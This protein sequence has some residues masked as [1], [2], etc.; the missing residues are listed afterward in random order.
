MGG[1]RFLERLFEADPTWAVTVFGDEPHP[2][3]DRVALSKVLA[4]SVGAETVVIRGHDWYDEKGIRLEAGCPIVAIN[5]EER[6]VEDAFGRQHEYDSLVLATGSLPFMPPIPGANLDGV[7][8]FRTLDEVDNMITRAEAG[9]KAVVIGGGLLGL[10]CAYGLTRRGMDVTVLHLTEH[11]MDRQLDLAAGTLLR[12]ELQRMGMRVMLPVSTK[13]FEGD[14]RVERVVLTDGE[15]IPADLVVICAGIRPNISLARDAGLS[16]AKGI[17]VDDCLHTSAPHV[18]ALGEC[19]EHKG[20]TFGLVEPVYDQAALLAKIIGHQELVAYE[21][22][23]SAT[24][25]KVA[26]LD[27]FAGGRS[28]PEIGDHEV[29]IRDDAGFIYKKLVLR[30][31]VVVGATLLGDVRSAPLVGAALS[32]G[33]IVKD[34]LRLLGIGIA[35]ESNPAAEL[36]DLAVVCGCNGVT[37]ATIMEAIQRPEEGCTSR[38]CVAKCTRASTSCGSCANIVDGLLAYAGQ[39][40]STASPAPVVCTCVPVAREELRWRI[41]GEDIRTVS[42]VLK[43]AGDGVGCHRCRPAINYYL[44]AWWC[45]DYQ[46]QPAS[47]HVNDRVHANVQKDGTFSVVPRMRGGITTPDDLRRIADVAD[48]Y[49]VGMVKLTGGQRIDLLGVKK[50]DLP[51]MWADLGMIS[52]HAYTKAIRTVKS[53]VGTEWCRF[54]V[55]DSTSLAVAMEEMLEG[56]YCPHKV[57]LGVTGCPRNCAEVTIKDLGVMA[58]VGAWEIYVGGAAGMSVRKADLLCTV[59]TPTQVLEEVAIAIQR[60]REEGIY[61][62]RMYHYVPR[63]GIDAFKASTVEASEVVR[64]GLLDRFRRS[65][66]RVSDPWQA[67]PAREPWRFEPGLTA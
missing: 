63:V 18:Y 58:I 4:G 62:E 43:T 38:A 25:L 24:T 5:T 45:G 57:K 28:V 40:A 13:R 59:E 14:G 47:R 29:V 11:L 21:P 66:A 56:L 17:V 67:V 15:V 6:W 2:A 49:K 37:K 8:P 53:C 46:E 64:A 33:T 30:N 54:G 55:G 7:L 19:I 34:R 3:Y 52:G 65:K 39:T 16:V 32:G 61:L 20:L 31:D 42:Q 48:K 22:K 36:P 27:V 51:L 41:L 9:S 60:Y 35:S 23:F 10:E 44:D 1:I 50:A 26:G 12:D